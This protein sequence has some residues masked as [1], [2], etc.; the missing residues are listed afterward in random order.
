M[1]VPPQGHQAVL[2]E[3]VTRTKA[4]AR[5]YV[6]WPGL[7]SDIEK[8]V[9]Q[10]VPCQQQQPDPPATPLQPWSWRS[11]TYGLCW[12]VSRQNDPDRHQFTLEM[13]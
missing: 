10:C 7:D 2:Q 12:P 13:D 3:F 4:L 5:M 11:T 8:S 9:Q 1:V 6:W